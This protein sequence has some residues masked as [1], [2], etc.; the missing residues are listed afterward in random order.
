MKP[1]KFALDHLFYPELS[2]KASQEYSPEDGVT[3]TEPTIKIFLNKTGVN[4]FHLGLRLNLSAEVPADKYSIEAL[5]SEHSGRMK[6][7]LKINK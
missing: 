1:A 5:Q 2:V 4:L 7:S 6:H 3:P